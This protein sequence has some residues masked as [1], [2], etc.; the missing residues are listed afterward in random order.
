MIWVLTGLRF[1]TVSL[2]AFLLLSPLV[3]RTVSSVEKPI[4]VIGMDNSASITLSGDSTFYRTEYLNRMNRLIADL[5]KY[6]DVKIYSFG[7]KLSK[8]MGT[9]FSEKETDIA[10][11]FQEVENRFS[12]RNAGAVIIASDGLYNKG[13]DPFYAAR[14]I[15]FPVYSIALGDTNVKKD[16]FIRKIT[17]S[18]T[19]FRGDQFPV[20]ILSELDKVKGI[21]CKVNLNLGSKTINSKEIISR[22]DRSLVKSTFL[23]ETAKA[24]I[25]RYSVSID[26]VDGEL[27]RMNN[28]RDFFVEVLDERQKIAIL[29][30][31][32]HPDITTFLK[33]LEG[34]SRFETEQFYAAEFNTPVEKFDLVILYQLPS[35]SGLINLNYLMK[36][37]IPVL[38]IL[39]S[40]SDVNA[41]NNLKTGLIINTKPSGFL[42][43][44][45][46]VNEGFSLFTMEKSDNLLFNDLPPLQ[47]PFGV[48]QTGPLAEVLFYQK[49]GAVAT[50]SPLFI[51]FP[52]P[53]KK[54]GIITGENIWRWRISD[55]IRAQDHTVFDRLINKIAHYLAVKED[56]S[57]F[58]IR[59]EDR[60]DENETVEFEAEVYNSSYE[61][62]NDPEVNIMITDTDNKKYPYVFSRMNRAYFLNVGILP[63]GNYNYAA[64]VRVGNNLYQKTGKFFIEQISVEHFNLL[65]DHQ[66]LNRISKTHDGEIIYPGSVDKLARKISG[67][68]DFRSVS[69]SEKR[70]SDLIGNP[71]LFITIILLL[72]VEWILR[73]RHGI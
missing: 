20:E 69:I 16:L 41:F 8:G 65:A 64:S 18:K 40:N 60:I 11:F 58:R 26:P 13:I 17:A 15:N 71:W 21:K 36:S 61:L 5:K 1:F 51:F 68:D 30:D 57:F 22:E 33:A 7:D 24:G 2:I 4:V 25:F 9:G 34:S 54:I 48:Y 66:L 52:N 29:Y 23:I 31:S 39:G 28:Q 56:K 53:D 42:E 63:V 35:R 59:V 47:S 32:P 55:F 67:R 3:K 62:I 72:T 6:C 45:P 38:F 49:V 14:K 73:K 37:K 70:F 19:V 10:S 12:N 44:Q 46:Q 27:N 43:V 50:T